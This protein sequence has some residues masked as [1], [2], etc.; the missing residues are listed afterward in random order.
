MW[1]AIDSYNYWVQKFPLQYWDCNIENNAYL[2]NCNNSIGIPNNFAKISAPWVAHRMLR[3]KQ[4]LLLLYSI[5]LTHKHCD[6]EKNTKDVLQKWWN[7]VKSTDLSTP[8]YVAGQIPNFGTVR[9]FSV[10]KVLCWMSS[11]KSVSDGFSED[12]GLCVYLQQEML[13][14]SALSIQPEVC[15]AN[16]F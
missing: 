16:Q 2:Y 10:V 9:I 15:S 1:L 4:N 14:E 11:N 13:R 5:K 12:H 8:N 7:E 3:K 6:I